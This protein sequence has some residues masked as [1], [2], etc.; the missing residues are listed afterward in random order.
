MVVVRNHSV[1]SD[2]DYICVSFEREEIHL[3]VQCKWLYC[4]IFDFFKN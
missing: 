4:Y 1:V 2:S 3:S